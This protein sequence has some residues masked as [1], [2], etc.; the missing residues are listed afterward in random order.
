MDETR[1]ELLRKNKFYLFWCRFF[2]DL[3]ALNAV[4]QLFYLQR[5]LSVSDI[6]LVGLAWPIGTLIADIPSSYLADRWGRRRTILTGVVL[7]VIAN[8]WLFYAHGFWSFFFYTF[9]FAISYSF[10]FGVEDA[11]LY[12]TLREMKQE[13][14]VLKTAGKYASAG[15]VSKILVPLL[16]LFLAKDLTPSQFNTL[17]Y[18]NLASSAI[19]VYFAWKL[20]EP[21]KFKEKLRSKLNAFTDGIRTFLRSKIL[22]SFAFNKSLIFSASFVFWRYYQNALHEQGFSILLLGIIYPLSNVILVAFFV[23]AP[24]ITEYVARLYLFNLVPWLT[25]ISTVVFVLTQ[26]TV[27][28]FSSSVILL[29]VATIRDPLFTQQIQWRIKS[30]SRAT[31]SSI[32]GIFKS[33]GDIP[34]L[35]LSAYLASLGGKSI[36]IIPTVLSLAAIVFFGIKKQYIINERLRD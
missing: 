23:M 31:T 20:I 9:A 16:G 36:L 6:Y 19:A 27:L 22:R 18:I 21:K 2:V 17:L 3:N 14:V 29:T 33:V 12:D 11:L 13:K 4:V 25:L 5:G 35:M 30:Y 10:F 7:N 32:L 34:I 8:A 26:N 28:L 15:R 1:F 24:K